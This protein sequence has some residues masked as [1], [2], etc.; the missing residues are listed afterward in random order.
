MVADGAASAAG[1]ALAADAGASRA[2]AASGATSRRNVFGTMSPRPGRRPSYRTY[3]IVDGQACQAPVRLTE[4]HRETGE[5]DFRPAISLI[6]RGSARWKT[7]RTLSRSSIG[8]W[9]D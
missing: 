7:G 4:P 6:D 5:N 3:I 8:P 9:G 2:R 1:A